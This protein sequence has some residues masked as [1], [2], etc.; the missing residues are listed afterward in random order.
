MKTKDVDVERFVKG[1]RWKCDMHFTTV[2][3][4]VIKSRLIRMCMKDLKHDTAR[5]RRVSGRYNA[6]L[7]KIWWKVGGNGEWMG[8]A[9]CDKCERWSCFQS[10]K[11]F[12]AFLL[13][14]FICS[15]ISKFGFSRLICFEEGSPQSHDESNSRALAKVKMHQLIGS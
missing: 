7:S 8:M 6:K 5:P 2:W 3:S 12:Y 4:F 13:K 9:D 1:E 10:C 11:M 15:Q 14:Q